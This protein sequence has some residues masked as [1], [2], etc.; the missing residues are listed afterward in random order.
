VPAAAAAPQGKPV[1]GASQ[2]G[3]EYDPEAQLVAAIAQTQRDIAREVTLNGEG[4]V[5]QALRRLLAEQ[6]T[7]L[8][9]MR[10]RFRAAGLPTPSPVP[11]PPDPGALP[12]PEPEI[13]P[14]VAAPQGEAKAAAAGQQAMLPGGQEALRQMGSSAVAQFAQGIVEN[15]TSPEWLRVRARQTLAAGQAAKQQEHLR[16]RP[17]DTQGDLFG[18]PQDRGQLFGGVGGTSGRANLPSGLVPMRPAVLSTREE[19]EAYVESLMAPARP[20]GTSAA[21]SVPAQAQA[22]GSAMPAAAAGVPEAVPPGE[23]AEVERQMAAVPA[24]RTPGGALA[25]PDGQPSGLAERLWRLVRT[26]W[27]RGRHGEWEALGLRDRVLATPEAV[28]DAETLRGARSLS[29]LKRAAVAWLAAH[30]GDRQVTNRAT[31]HPIRLDPTSVGNA[32]S[33]GIG[34]EKAAAGTVLDRLIEGAVPVARDTTDMKPSVVAVET[35]AC[36]LRVGARAYVA[37]LVV[38]Q[39]QDGRRFY[40]HELSTFDPQEN[41]RLGSDDS[42][43]SGAA[44]GAVASARPLPSLGKNTARGA[45]CQPRKRDGGAGRARGTAGGRRGQAGGEGGGGV[46]RAGAAE[47]AGAAGAGRNGGGTGGPGHPLGPERAGGTGAPDLAA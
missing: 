23:R 16:G 1:A 42:G 3:A 6:Q 41:A 44:F 11:A 34:P 15:P 22:A 17:V 12:M 35:F 18:T 24:E 7:A 47:G 38:R 9:A 32:L 39:L 29:D 13:R 20:G 8:A 40:D 19:A 4:G 25:A 10:E 2:E 27:F 30:R 33:H 26:P 45:E 21:A 28:A 5:A 37:R 43:D 31:G 46:R 14:A 36:R